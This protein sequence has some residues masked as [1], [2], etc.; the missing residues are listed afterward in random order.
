MVGIESIKKAVSE[1]IVSGEVK[2]ILVDT[3]GNIISDIPLSAMMRTRV[4]EQTFEDGTTDTSVNNATQT[5]QT[6][7][8]YAGTYALQVTIAAGNTGYVETPARPVSPGQ[9]VTFSFAHKEN[10]NIV[11]IKL[12]V[13]WYRANLNVISTEEFTLTASTSWQVDTRTVTAPQNAAYMGLRMQATAGASDG[14]VYLDDMFIDL[15]GQI[16]R[17]DGAGQIKVADTDLLEELQT[18]APKDEG[19]TIEIC[20]NADISG[21]VTA[22]LKNFKRWTLYLKTADAIDITI[23]LSPDGGTTWF[24]VPESPVSFSAAGDDVIEFGYDATHIRLTG[25]NTNAVTAIIRGVF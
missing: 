25:S 13:V 3:D 2:V 23:E 24:T 4:Y 16:F 20:T 22:E 21:G 14:N 6:S 12:I 15:V 10:A 17:V 7:E 19:E 5:V 8:V 1:V 18:K 9:K 11:D